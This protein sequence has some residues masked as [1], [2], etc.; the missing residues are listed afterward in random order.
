MPNVTLT[1]NVTIRPVDPATIWGI[2]NWLVYR[3]VN[4][5]EELVP[6]GVHTVAPT[7][8]PGSDPETEE[9]LAYDFSYPATPGADQIV[10]TTVQYHFVPT[11]TE[12]DLAE[13]H[14]WLSPEYTIVAASSAALQS[15]SMSMSLAISL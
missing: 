8:V 3:I 4:S 15:S 7:V 11:G 9:T 6:L 13:S 12:A 10:G 14:D 2:E 1:R 5:S